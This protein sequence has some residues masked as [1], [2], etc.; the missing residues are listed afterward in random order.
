MFNTC[1][2]SCGRNKSP[3][4]LRKY[5]VLQLVK[6][7]FQFRFTRKYRAWVYHAAPISEMERDLDICN[8]FLAEPKMLIT[9]CVSISFGFFHVH[10]GQN[11]SMATRAHHISSDIQIF[12]LRLQ[13]I[14]IWCRHALLSISNNDRRK[15]RVALFFDDANETFKNA[16]QSA[17]FKRTDWCSK[18]TRA[19]DERSVNMSNRKVINRRNIFV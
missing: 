2:F 14:W 4:V 10:W 8:F 17:T 13:S 18:G 19:T 9:M 3:S 1:H 6:N 16:K 7:I 12:T 5:I 15:R 11:C